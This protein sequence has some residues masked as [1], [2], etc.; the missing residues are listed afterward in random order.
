MLEPRATRRR[1]RRA[2]RRAASRTARATRKRGSPCARARG[3]GAGGRSC[4]P[5]TLRDVRPA[6]LRAEAVERGG[7]SREARADDLLEPVPIAARERLATATGCRASA[8][9]PGDP[10][11]SRETAGRNPSASASRRRR[12]RRRPGAWWRSSGTADRGYT[13]GACPTAPR[14]ST[15]STS[16]CRQAARGASSG[17]GGA[18]RPGARGDRSLAADVDVAQ[19]RRDRRLRGRH[20]RPRLH[21]RRPRL[22]P[23]RAPSL[24][25]RGAAEATP[26]AVASSQVERRSTPR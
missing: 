10:P 26:L 22:R 1:R 14:S 9:G 17:A 25:S 20:V 2:A 11:L 21:S 7:I 16:A 3:A 13:L 18:D 5:E 4:R 23:P 19:G 15:T 24:R 12:K 8:R 6:E